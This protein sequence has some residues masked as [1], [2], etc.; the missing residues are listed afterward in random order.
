MAESV[1][2]D[3]CLEDALTGV[4][5]KGAGEEKKMSS[6]EREVLEA[7]SGGM[8]TDQV[9]KKMYVKVV[10]EGTRQFNS[11]TIWRLEKLVGGFLINYWDTFRAHFV[12]FSKLDIYGNNL[13]QVFDKK[14]K[15]CCTKLNIVFSVSQ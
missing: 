3:V 14:L 13:P 7:M 12:E 9:T 11:T 2:Q 4:K 1:K 8:S 6:M 10:R 15:R 5:K